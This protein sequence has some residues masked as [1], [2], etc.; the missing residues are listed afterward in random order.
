MRDD[1]SQ[2][3]IDFYQE[4]GFII[5]EDFLSPEELE[6]W[7]RCVD[8]A[9]EQREGRKLAD[10][11][12]RWR[13]TGD[14]YYSNVFI[15]RINLW[16]DHEG[17]RKLMFDERIGRM[18]TLL[19][20]ADGMRIWHDQALIKPPWGNPTAW[21]LDVPYW[22]FT[23]RQAISLWVALDDST[24]DNGCLYFLPGTHKTATFDNVSIGQN[25]GGLIRVYPQWA[26]V[27]SVAAPMRAGSCSFHNGL[28][29]H[30][31]AANMTPGWRR[32]MTCA[33]MPDGSTFNGQQ[34]ILPPDMFERLQ[35]GDLLDEDA[36]N[37][38]LWRRD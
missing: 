9:V 38:L 10:A 34:N 28:C 8:E 23:S 12:E 15:Q 27:E 5:I 36:Q 35:I 30:G 25:Q 32:A 2:E 11:G 3:Q 26:K 4:N 33:Y 37:P 29:A 22:S 18:A 19:A 14:T 20:G 7:R 16:T 24:R 17:M 6:E 21:H 1:I 31:A 13:D